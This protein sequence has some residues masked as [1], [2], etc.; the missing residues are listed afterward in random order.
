MLEAQQLLYVGA[1]YPPLAK[2]SFTQVN[3]GPEGVKKE[4]SEL[5][6]A[7]PGRN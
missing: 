6:L 5:V 1:F 4:T 3:V 2:H 7:A